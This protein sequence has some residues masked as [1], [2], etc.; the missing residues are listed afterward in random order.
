MA[1]VEHSTLTGAEL[2]E[3]IRW[4]QAAD[5]AGSAND[6]DLWL[7]TDDNRLYVRHSAAWLEVSADVA[8]HT[9]VEAD[10]T[11]FAH[12]HDAADLT[13]GTV[14]TAR[15]GS[16]T[17]DA[18]TFLRGDQTWQAV[19]GGL[20][21]PTTTKGD[22]LARDAS[23]VTR[24]GVGTDG[25]VLT[26]DAAEATGVKWAAA[27]SGFAD[28]MTTA[29]DLIRRSG[30]N[31]TE[32]LAVGTEGHVLTVASGLP[33]WAAPSG[34]GAVTQIAQTVLG[35][36]AASIA[37]SS[38]PGTYE[39]LRIVMVGRGDAA[40]V[41]TAVGARFNADSGV[42]Y[43]YVRLRGE[44]TA[45]S[46]TDDATETA[47]WIGYVLGA[48]DDVASRAGVLESL[49]PGYARTDWRKVAL[50]RSGYY[51]ADGG[52]NIRT[53]VEFMAFWDSTAAITQI[54]LVPMSG[55]NFLAG[56]VATLYGVG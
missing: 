49:V 6:G 35:S 18:T 56:T 29:G 3:Q 13:A 15:L 33:A 37:F 20:T 55:G 1:N 36:A 11:D 2:H 25:H 14:A 51:L 42:N 5:P 53:A 24:L 30:A 7:D 39:D 31:A 44:N 10:I 40:V 21:D 47:A 52:T 28:P 19:A 54:D 27:A 48:S 34:G 43:Q 12:A 32:R 46:S 9:H 26:A 38:I 50:S 8:G 17:A 41:A 23:A 45:A 16:G 22:L 4:R